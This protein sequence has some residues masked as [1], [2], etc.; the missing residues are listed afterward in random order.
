MLETNIMKG[1]SFIIKLGTNKTVN[2]KGLKIEPQN[3]AVQNQGEM[4]PNFQILFLYG[5]SMAES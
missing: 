2:T 3:I 5:V 4:L 1:K